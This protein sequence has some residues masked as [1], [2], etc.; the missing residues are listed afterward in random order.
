MKKIINIL[1]LYP[2]EMSIYGDFGNVLTL[3]RRLEWRGYQVNITLAG[4][5]EDPKIAGADI[6]F[7]GGGQDRGQQAVGK[8]LQRHA[9]ALRAASDNNVPI[10]TIC[11]A[12]QLFGHKFATLDGTV[13][14]GIG[15]FDAETIGSKDR[16][17]G[18]IIIGT[19]FGEVVG[20]ENHSGKTKLLNDQKPFGIVKKGHGNDGNA[21][22][23]GARTN[24]T[25]GTYSH[26]PLLPKN[27]HF[28]DHL[29]LTALNNKYGVTELKAL[30][31]D[32]ENQA[33]KSAASRPQ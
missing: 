2:R 9:K 12:Y 20:F 6:I 19:E 11:G 4:V 15:I 23:E 7:A 14:P 22:H 1:H 31:D 25:F 26:G 30:E 5:G 16:M 18:N 10:L 27:P 17:I 32:L 21:K 13:I 28:C 24:N 3:Q 29:I 8:D 33:H